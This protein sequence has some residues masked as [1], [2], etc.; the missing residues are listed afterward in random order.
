[1]PR[2]NKRGVGFYFQILLAA[3]SRI[4]VGGQAVLEGVMMRVP[5]YYAVAVR[6]P[7]GVIQFKRGKYIS[8]IDSSRVL[9]L[10]I[11]RG[12]IN[13]FE[14]MKLGLDT[15]NWSAEI[16]FPEEVESGGSSIWATLLAFTLAIG[17]FFVAPLLLTT[18][19]L[20]VEQ[21]AIAFNLISGGF[22]IVF[23]LVYLLLISLMEDVKRL[24]QYHGAEHK[25]IYTFEAG[26]QLTVDNSKKYSTFHPRCGTS[27]LF[28]VLL[29]AILTFA[30]IDTIA[31]GLMGQISLGMRL[32]IHLPLIPLVA[33]IGYEVL[34][35]VARHQKLALFR[36]LAQPGLWLQRITTSTPDDDQM[37]VAFE[38]LKQA[39]GDQ[40]DEHTGHEFVA[41]AIG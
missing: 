4:L 25:A 29:A 38:S 8:R 7:E 21:D 5:G 15:L 28:I 34:K 33:G 31:I 30:L 2:V 36:W 10:P 1:M 12:V 3:Q 13:L 19:L 6:D 24:F 26:D 32:L 11:L 27:F 18:K 39:F 23:F 40:L 37:D 9:K 14:S 35:F 17:L 16:A 20:N 41:D 22:R